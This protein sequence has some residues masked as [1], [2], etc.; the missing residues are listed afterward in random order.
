MKKI[1]ITV[2]IAILLWTGMLNN[3][4]AFHNKIARID[5][6]ENEAYPETG[7]SGMKYLNATSQPESDT[8]TAKQFAV[9]STLYSEK[10]IGQTCTLDTNWNDAISAGIAKII[11]GYNFTNYTIENANNSEM[12]LKKNL[13]LTLVI[14]Q[15][16]LDK[17]VGSDFNKVLKNGVYTNPQTFFETV[18]NI[19]PN[20]ILSQAN[21][22]YNRVKSENDISAK[23]DI[24]RDDSLR[25][26]IYNPAN[27]SSATTSELEIDTTHIDR[28]TLE[29]KIYK[30]TLDNSAIPEGIQIKAYVSSDKNNFGE[31]KGILDQSTGSMRITDLPQTNKFYIKFELIDSRTDKSEE[32]KITAAANLVGKSD[33]KIAAEYNCGDNKARVTPNRIET[34]TIQEV[35]GFTFKTP[36]IPE[37]PSVQIINTDSTNPTIMLNNAK[38]KISYSVNNE[39]VDTSVII[40]SQGTDGKYLYEDIENNGQYCIEGEWASSGYLL[41][42]QKHCFNVNMDPTNG[43]TLSVI[44]NDNAIEYDEN[45]EI[46]KI[47]LESIKNSIKLGKINSAKNSEKFL[48]GAQLKLTKQTEN[49]EEEMYVW[50]T[51]DEL[52]KELVG[53]PKGTYYLYEITAPAGYI[54]NTER[55]I[56]TSRL[57]DTEPKVYTIDDSRTKIKIRKVDENKHLL[58]GAVLQITDLEG[59]V[60][61][62]PWTTGENGETDHTVIGLETAKKYYLEELSAPKGYSVTSKIRFQ[63]SKKGDLVI[64]DGEDSEGNTVIISNKKN[65][66][67]SNTSNNDNKETNNTSSNEQTSEIIITT[68]DTPKVYISIQDITNKGTELP[69]AVLELKNQNGKEILTWESTS[70]PRLFENLEQGTYIVTEVTAPNDY[71]ASESISFTIDKEGNV[72]GETVIYNTPIIN[73][74]STAAFQSILFIAIGIVLVG[75]GVGLYIYGIKKKKEI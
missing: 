40:G 16:L 13:Q 14:N 64:L 68:I 33:Y 31:A 69:G 15:F 10:N 42:N 35:K 30:Q 56:V 9:F 1:L 18:N 26:V 24:K 70:N 2:A 36:G 62:G 73:A 57:T 32:F 74:P 11:E 28:S 66:N 34:R 52:T 20:N 7:L 8:Q 58:V 71:S 44:E 75:S 21:D 17:N 50:N 37:Y 4:Y 41:N 27:S 51:T 39:N 12:I 55:T 67:T 5:S 3:V 63:L 59:N 61:E 65:T 38:Y 43:Y 29:L 25:K 6:T 72:I 23:I 49:G 47:S 48:P 60:V 46:I 54:L 19:D 45:H 53:L 22:E